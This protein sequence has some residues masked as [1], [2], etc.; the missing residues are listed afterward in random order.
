MI[1]RLV[2][3][4]T[5]VGDHPSRPGS[6]PGRLFGRDGD[7][8]RWCDAGDGLDCHAAG[9][10]QRRRKICKLLGE[11]SIKGNKIWRRLVFMFLFLLKY[12]CRN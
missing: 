5:T 11:F 4:R 8:K 7:P 2:L 10:I 12:H 1:Q 3:R 9:G 6:R